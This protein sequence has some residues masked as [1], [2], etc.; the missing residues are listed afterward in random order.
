MQRALL[1]S[2]QYS[3]LSTGPDRTGTRRYLHAL[4]R[5]ANRP[6]P[7]RHVADRACPVGRSA[8]FYRRSLRFW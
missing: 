5:N 1:C 6:L 7:R 8:L 2:T 4:H 3:V